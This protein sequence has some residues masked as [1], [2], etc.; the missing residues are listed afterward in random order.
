MS[1]WLE[2]NYNVEQGFTAA[3][4]SVLSNSVPI[5]ALRERAANADPLLQA[6]L[7]MA[8]RVSDSAI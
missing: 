1:C 2:K 5:G 4:S 3:F 8:H 7:C 6:G